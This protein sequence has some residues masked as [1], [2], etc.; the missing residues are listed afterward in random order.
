[1]VSCATTLCIAM[2]PM[3]ISAFMPSAPAP[4]E[5]ALWATHQQY[6]L[7]VG[8]GQIPLSSVSQVRYLSSVEQAVMHD[9]LLSSVQVIHEGELVEL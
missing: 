8:L 3:T 5:E 6:G 4:K 1:M 2:A 7:Q 9:S